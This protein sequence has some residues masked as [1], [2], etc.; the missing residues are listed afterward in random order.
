MAPQALT[1]RRKVGQAIV[2]VAGQMAE[3]IRPLPDTNIPIPKSEWS[4]G[5][6][7]A[8]ISDAQKLFARLTSGEDVRHGDGTVESL[9]PANRALLNRN[10]ERS[11]ESLANALVNNTQDYLQSAASTPPSKMMVTPM[12]PMDADTLYTYCLLHLM[13]HGFPISFALKKNLKVDP[14]TVELTI[15]FLKHALP[16]VVNRKAAGKLRAI[17]KVSMRGGS[18]FWIKFDRGDVTV[19]DSKPGRVDC[20]I[21]ADP[22]SFLLVG[23]KLKSQWPMI[24][25]GKLFAYGI[26]PWLGFRFAGLFLPP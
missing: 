11:G 25:Q 8:H 13:M 21:S 9:A 18:S 7:A 14:A 6:M 22:V 15:P 10:Q 17:Y 2:S 1:D 19:H 26:K 5:E 3:M 16:V 24:A 4:V 20:F 12:G 23:F